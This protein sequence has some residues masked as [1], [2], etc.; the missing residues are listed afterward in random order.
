[1]V[2]KPKDTSSEI[3]PILYIKILTT[4]LKTTNSPYQLGL[5]TLKT[6]LHFCHDGQRMNHCEVVISSS[7]EEPKATAAASSPLLEGVSKES[8][9]K[10]GANPPS[11]D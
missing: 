3:T 2:T 9:S 6:T 4:S 8:R 11:L 7:W 10:E 5:T 1:M